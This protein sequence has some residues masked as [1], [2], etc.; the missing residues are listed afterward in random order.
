M[1]DRGDDGGLPVVVMPGVDAGHGA[2]RR[3]GAVA[4][5]DE[6][7]AERGAIIK[8]QG[9]PRIVA[10]HGD[11]AR[12]YRMDPPGAAHR[13][14]ERLS[15][16]PV[17]HDPSH[18]MFTDIAMVVVK[19]EGRVAIGDADIQDGLGRGGRRHAMHPAVRERAFEPQEMEDTR[20]SNE[21]S[22]I[23]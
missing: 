10:F 21:P 18:G 13:A 8:A 23:V 16:D 20:P 11:N 7:A 12:A 6:T 1:T 14:I 3:T 15:E 4:G 19:E 9:C 2:Q 5:N 22:R 17:F